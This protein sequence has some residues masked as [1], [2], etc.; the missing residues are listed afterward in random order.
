M[1]LAAVLAVRNSKSRPI[2]PMLALYG[3]QLV[4]N[5]LWSWLFFHWH[6]GAAAFVDSAIMLLLI[7]ATTLA[8]WRVRRVAGLLMLPYLAWVTFATALSYTMWRLNPGVL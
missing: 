8:F 4:A 6:L 1:A 2:A 5:G 3:A 7:A